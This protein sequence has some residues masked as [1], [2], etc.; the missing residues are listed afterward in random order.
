MESEGQGEFA[1]Y[2]PGRQENPGLGVLR[3]EWPA[4][5]EIDSVSY[6]TVVHAYWALAA[7]DPAAAAQIRAAGRAQ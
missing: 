2:R 7:A 1:L 5:I 4:P 3:N 6:P